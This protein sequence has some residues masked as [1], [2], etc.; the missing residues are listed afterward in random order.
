MKGLLIGAKNSSTNKRLA[1]VALKAMATK[2]IGEPL[3]R[4]DQS[5]YGW[6]D[7]PESLV[8]M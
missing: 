6:D 7:R 5:S 2:P 4:P 1:A 3:C 8:K